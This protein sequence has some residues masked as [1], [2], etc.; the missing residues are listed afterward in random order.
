MDDGADAVG[1]AGPIK[2]MVG[3][4]ASDF[5]IDPAGVYWISVDFMTI[6]RATR[7]P[8]AESEA[9]ADQFLQALLDAMGHQAT[10]LVSAFNFQF[11]QTK[12]FDV[13][14]A[15]VQTGAFGSLLLR[16]HA[17]QRTPRPFYSFL[18]FGAGSPWLLA[19]RFPN[20]TGPDSVF[21]WIVDR[22][23]ELVTIGH[24]YVK[25]LTSVHH[26]ENVVGIPYRY[27]KTFSGRV[28]GPDRDEEAAVTF[29]VRALD[30]C[31]HSSLTFAGDE[32]FRRL[33]MIR[34][35]PLGPAD[36]PLLAHKV[37]LA[38]THREMV[39]DLRHDRPKYVDYL[40]KG[41]E[42]P[43]VITPQSANK[44]YLDELASL[45]S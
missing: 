39:E 33:G 32:H 6:L 45:R 35:C 22:K 23:T 24:H 36:R 29:Y 10:L 11:P 16:R 4:L 12:V 30:V 7:V 42:N 3:K 43:C 14:T 9:F 40:G 26:A 41:R 38:A 25:S 27:S 15:P 31:D 1:Q 19:Q 21:E 2:A 37:N 18:A 5:F 34:T 13:A 8:P 28:V 20:S 17:R 44:L